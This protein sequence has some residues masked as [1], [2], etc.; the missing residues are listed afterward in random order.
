[1]GALE[2]NLA[3]TC[4]VPLVPKEDFTPELAR[5]AERVSKRVGMTANNVHAMANAPELGGI[6]RGF[7]DDVWDH[8]E[9][10]K[11]LK[12][13]IRHKVSNINACLYCSAHQVRVMM[14]QNV[15]KEKIDNMHA[16]ESHP[17][18]TKKERAALAFAEALTID[19][20]NIPIAIQKRAVDELNPQESVEVS[21]IATAMGVLNRLNHAL[22]VP[23]EEP[24]HDIG[25]TI[26]F[27]KGED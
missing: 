15:P 26:S 23:L 9:L 5:S 22:N 7:L 21:I 12:A 4:L 20:S 6:V 25:R 19:A 24:M 13:L 2:K 17:D 14:S 27:D 3:K 10:P 8:G 16:Y 11:P 1:M 18:F